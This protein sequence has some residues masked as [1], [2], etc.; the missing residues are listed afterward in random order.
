M[1]RKEG[2]RVQEEGE[3]NRRGS[4]TFDWLEQEIAAVKTRRF[5]EVDGPASE[6]PSE[7]IESSAKEVPQSY[8]DFVLRFGNAKLY[9]QQ[10]GYLLGVRATPV[11]TVSR[12]GERFL[13]F[14]HYQESQV[15]FKV[16][17]LKEGAESP[18]FE[19]HQGALKEV[20]PGFLEWLK[21]RS[22][23][24]R[25]AF[26]KKRWA[27]IVRG[28]SP[29]TAREAAI[30]DARK[31]FS[32]RNVGID[33]TGDVLFEVHN[34]SN[35]TLPF[36]SVGVQDKRGGFAGRVWLPVS[37]IEPGSTAVVKHGAYKDNIERTNLDLYDL[38]DPE[39]EDRLSYWEFKDLT[40]AK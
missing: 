14:G 16:D 11:E 20:A 5:F 37:H 18:V 21:K 39:P 19:N 33:E 29:F 32:W 25:K 13:C 15:C 17:L 6:D 27:Q 26:G 38:P 36:Y 7:T 2:Q 24:A 31:A 9:K 22:A 35:A 12:T 28:P 10:A 23:D 30:V 8:K 4:K 40:T 3:K 34:G 1:G